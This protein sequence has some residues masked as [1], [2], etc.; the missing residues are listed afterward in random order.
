MTVFQAFLD[1]S[2]TN[3]ET[4]VL[5]VGGFYGTKEQWETFRCCR[6]SPAPVVEAKT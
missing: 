3:P 1:E 2:G 6:T 4:P 5:T